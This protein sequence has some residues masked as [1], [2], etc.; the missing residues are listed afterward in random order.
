MKN[1]NPLDLDSMTAV[2]NTV[3]AIEAFNDTISGVAGSRQHCRRD[4]CCSCHNGGG[5]RRYVSSWQQCPRLP[6]APLMVVLGLAL[7]MQDG[8]EQAS[9]VNLGMAQRMDDLFEAMSDTQVADVQAHIV[10]LGATDIVGAL[11]AM[12]VFQMGDRTTVRRIRPLTNFMPEFDALD[13]EDAEALVL[14]N[15]NPL[16]LTA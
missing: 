16:D 11:S 4:C 5:R 3:D 8:G 2:T 1:A 14:E 10:N 13:D 7:M 15:A 6:I 12:G 9:P